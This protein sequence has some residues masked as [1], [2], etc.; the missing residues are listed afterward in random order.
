M[1]HPNMIHGLTK[2]AGVAVAKAR[3][4]SQMG[5]LQSF[6]AAHV[7][8]TAATIGVGALAGAAATAWW[9]KANGGSELEMHE[10]AAEKVGEEVADGIVNWINQHL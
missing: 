5:G 7:G 2:A 8:A 9:V 1:L 10:A 6:L 3:M 4:L